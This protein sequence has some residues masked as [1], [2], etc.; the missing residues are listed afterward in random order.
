MV[1]WILLVDYIANLPFK[2]FNNNFNAI[3]I[4]NYIL[5]DHYHFFKLA[6]TSTICIAHTLDNEI[7]LNTPERPFLCTA[8]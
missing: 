3:L 1:S 8:S 6:D 5:Y 4:Q 7:F 2:A